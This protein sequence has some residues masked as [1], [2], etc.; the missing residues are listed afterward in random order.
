MT[1]NMILTLRVLLTCCAVPATLFVLLYGTLAPWWRSH[2]GRSLLAAACALAL[3]LDVTLLSR[4]Y[5]DLFPVRAWFVIEATLLF[6]TAFGLW[7]LLSVL[8]VTLLSRWNQD[9]RGYDEHT[10]IQ[11]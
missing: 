5:P 10:F 2:T 6:F 11:G 9:Q 7:Y 3:L 4:F 1:E 8:G